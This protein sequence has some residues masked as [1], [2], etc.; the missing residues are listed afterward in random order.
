MSSL[1]HVSR[2]EYLSKFSPPQMDA[3][4]KYAKGNF[5][6]KNYANYIES[7]EVID[8]RHPLVVEGLRV[9][10]KLGVVSQR[11]YTVLIAF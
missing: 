11:M 4:E 9:L 5:A 3:I 1:H 6:V 7:N 10:V 2:E 8:T